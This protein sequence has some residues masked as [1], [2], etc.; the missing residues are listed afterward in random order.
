MKVVLDA[1]IF[2][3]SFFWGGK[4]RK[5]LDRIMKEIDELYV[6]EEILEEV[7]DVIGRPKFRAEKSEKD[8]YLRQIE[9]IGCKVIPRRLTYNG[10]RDKTDDKYIE[11]GIAG[12]VD[13]II[14][15]DIHLLEIKEYENIKI[16][17]AGEYLET[18]GGL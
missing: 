2:V 5:V 11:C 1:N 18:V 16:V 8:Y 4:P 12:N 3:S 13:Y 10:S 7:S 15:G 6:T 9:E 17:T 14:S